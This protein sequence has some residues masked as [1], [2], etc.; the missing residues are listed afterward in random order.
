[1]WPAI[2]SGAAGVAAASASKTRDPKEK[3]PIKT[4]IAI[5]IGAF[6]ALALYKIVGKEIKDAIQ[7]KKNKKM[8]ENEQDPKVKLT[9]KP[10]Q[11]VAWSDKI[12]D[13]M[14]ANWLDFTDEEAIYSIMRKLKTN[15][16]WLELMKSYGKRKYYDPT[17]ATYI[18]GKDIN[19]L[20]ALQLE[21]D[22]KEKNK[23]NTILKNNGIRYRI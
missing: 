23:V 16:D 7:K 3:R 5:G 20:T 8:F 11:Y 10:T 2:I 18:F 6:T 22:T 17:S 1:M 4:A 9:Y 12:E 14:N 15:N 19:L 13:A 21:L